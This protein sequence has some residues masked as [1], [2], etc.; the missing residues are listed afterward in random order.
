MHVKSVESSNV[1][2]LGRCGNKENGVPELGCRLRHLTMNQN[3]EVAA[4]LDIS[5]LCLD[6]NDFTVLNC[7]V[8][9][10]ASLPPPSLWLRL[11]SRFTSLAT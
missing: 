8:K 3:Y 1:L 10:H 11:C 6:P 2:P 5:R 7:I 4:I 9:G